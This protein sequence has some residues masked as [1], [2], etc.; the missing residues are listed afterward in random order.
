ME[1]VLTATLGREE[2]ATVP[3]MLAMLRHLGLEH[4]EGDADGRRR[5]QVSGFAGEN[6]LMEI[7]ALLNASFTG[8]QPTLQVSHSVLS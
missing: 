5:L 1:I 2:H 7:V 6:R 4:M 8:T 3:E